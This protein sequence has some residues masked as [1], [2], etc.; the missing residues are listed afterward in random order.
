[1][2][3][4]DSV[5]ENNRLNDIEY[6]NKNII[7]R[8]YPKA[9]FVQL[10]APCNQNCLF[11]SRPTAYNH[12]D[13][14]EFKRNYEDQLS[15]AFQYAERINLTGSGEMLLLPKAK[16]NL[17]YFNY[18]KY[19]EKMFA[20]N[21]SSLTPKMIDFIIES[22]NRYV[23]HLSV[24]SSDA[25]LHKVMTK[26]DNYGALK[27]NIEYLKKAKTHTDKLKVNY[28]FV[29]TTKNIE[30]LSS[31]VAFAKDNNADSVIVY[32]NYIYSL[33]QKYLSCYFNRGKTNRSIDSAKKEA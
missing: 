6:E 12:F 21:G 7:L 30:N 24:H 25:L 3:S 20:T 18:F 28:V 31:F 33:D 10:D 14:E 4:E 27:E 23:I 9:V 15:Q 19:S 16:E 17:K 8:S 5:K 26:S 2:I 11:C 32:Y 22:D 1:M 29:A 13:L